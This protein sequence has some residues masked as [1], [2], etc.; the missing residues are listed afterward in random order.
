MAK[1]DTFHCS[2]ITPERAVLDADATFVAFPAHDGEVGILPGRAP[3]LFK[4]GIGVLRVESPTV[5]GGEE[6][7]FVD[8]GFAQMVEDRLTILTEQAKRPAEIDRVAAEKAFAAAHDLPA[9][10]DAEF[11]ARQ[12]ALERAR[13]QLRMIGAAASV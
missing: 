13:V 6:Q 9:E 3:L 7:L 12:R 1:G 2:V 11:A 5:A 4:L 8:G 10:S